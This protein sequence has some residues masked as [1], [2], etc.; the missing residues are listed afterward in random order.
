[1]TANAALGTQSAPADLA[2]GLP[3]V[4]DRKI[5]LT[6]ALGFKGLPNDA[7][8]HAG[9]ISLPGEHPRQPAC[10][11]GHQPRSDQC[12]FRVTACMAAEQ[13]NHPFP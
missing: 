11:L 1:M 2:A 12:S 13:E 3:L 4:L 5:V 9:R 6:H 10:S 7:V 8:C